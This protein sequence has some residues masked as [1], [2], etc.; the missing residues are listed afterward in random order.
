MSTTG[1]EAALLQEFGNA[2]TKYYM[3][4]YTEMKKFGWFEYVKV[5]MIIK[6]SC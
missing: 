1:S 4:R 5:L 2:G 6:D 3:P